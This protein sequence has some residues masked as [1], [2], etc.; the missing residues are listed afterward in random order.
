VTRVDAPLLDSLDIRFFHQLIFDSPQLAQFVARTP[1]IQPHVEARID[2][3]DDCVE[4]TSSR[5]FPRKFVLGIKCRQSDWQLSS[6]V[7]IC[8]SS[9]PEAFISTMD[10][11]YI[12]GWSPRWQDDIEDSQWLEVLHPFTAVK[13]LYL[14]RKFVSRIAPALQELAGEVLPS[15]GSLNRDHHHGAR[16]PRP[17][18][19][20][21]IDRERQQ[22]ASAMSVPL[23]PCLRSPP[24]P[25]ICSNER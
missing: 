8:G 12:S 11:L 6:L 18:P 20:A 25:P 23:S 16:F 15:G 4:V 14:S 13:H 10:H 1:N 5:T 7:Q 9:F 21:R 2:F 3:F 22:E 24:A 19:W 17:D